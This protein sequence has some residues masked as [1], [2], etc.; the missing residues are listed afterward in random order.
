M[1]RDEFTEQILEL[2]KSL[3]YVSKSILCNDED[4][5]DAI[6]NTI[7]KAYKNLGNLRQE[8]Y[9]KTWIT[10]IL[11][12]ECYQIAKAYKK[13]VPYEEYMEEWEEA[14]PYSEVYIEI[15]NLEEKY[16]VPFVLHYIEGFSLQEISKMLKTTESGIKMRLL[17]ARRILKEQ[18][19]Y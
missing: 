19:L 3:Y 2:E 4:C 13:Q 17:R 6:Q 1:S 12:N 9:F 7:L 5:K 15:Q 10:R 8:C 16:R 14:N 11:I 18:L